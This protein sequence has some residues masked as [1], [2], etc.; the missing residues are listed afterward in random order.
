MATLYDAP[1]EDLIEAVA[2]DLSDRIDAPD[3]AA[4]AKTGAAKELPPEEE[5][6]HVRAASVLRKIA[7]NGPV[8][9]ERLSTEY[10]DT[11]RGTNRYRVAPPRRAD[12]SGSVLRTICQQLEAENLIEIAEGQGRQVTP[13]GRSLL[14]DTA[15]DVIEDLDRPELQRYA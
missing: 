3:W 6:W 11:K 12:G 4:I 9:I 8:G 2:A 15:G 13:E 5:F 7:I 1:A 10:G 14:D